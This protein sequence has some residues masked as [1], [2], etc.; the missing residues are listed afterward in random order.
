MKFV[1][2]NGK[3]IE[4]SD[5]KVREIVTTALTSNPFWMYSGILTKDD[6]FDFF[7]GEANE[8]LLEKISYYILFYVENLV[9]TG[10]LIKLIEDPTEAEDYLNYN[11][12]L[13]EELRK[14]NKSKKNYETVNKM[15]RLCLKYGFDPF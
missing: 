1:L 5:A 7:R 14:L 13:L 8:Q 6:V 11:K 12:P 4:I 15:V 10:Y 3:T 2:L 9:L